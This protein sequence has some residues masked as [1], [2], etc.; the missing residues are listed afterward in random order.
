MTLH[1]DTFIP[2]KL[3]SHHLRF[4][5]LV[6]LFLTRDEN[7]RSEWLS[8]ET[9]ESSS[10]NNLDSELGISHDHVRVVRLVLLDSCE[11]NCLNQR[12]DYCLI[13]LL[14]GFLDLMFCFSDSVANC[15]VSI[16]PDI[17]KVP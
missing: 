16:H 15:G 13:T 2:Y 1:R 4:P 3:C 6:P 9:N 7:S 14:L 8:V 17:R 10:V 5:Q 11:L 12:L